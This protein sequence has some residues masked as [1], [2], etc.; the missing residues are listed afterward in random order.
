MLVLVDA[1]RRQG[2]TAEAV[3]V[4]SEIADPADP[5]LQAE[6][7]VLDSR[8]L[9]DAGDYHKCIEEFGRFAFGSTSS[10]SEIWL[11]TNL[12][13]CMTRLGKLE[14]ARAVFRHVVLE[15]E[16]NGWKEGVARTEMCLGLLANRDRNWPEALQHLNAS[17]ELY[18]HLGLMK[19]YMA[20]LL[21]IG[22]IHLL[23]GDFTR[24]CDELG[25]AVR[26]ASAMHDL[27]IEVTGRSD[28]GLALVRSN[29]LGSAREELSRALRL[30]RRQPS[31]RRLAIALEYTGEYHIA[32]KQYKH[33]G[34]L[35]QKALEIGNRIAPGGD[36]V[37]EVLRRLAEVALYEKR[38]EDAARIAGEAEQKAHANR[39]RYELATILRV[40]GQIADTTGSK[41]EAT[42]YWREALAILKELDETFEHGRVLK[43]LGMKQPG[44]GPSS[45]KPSGSDFRG[46]T[47]EELVALLR[48]N[49]M[50]GSSPAMVEV[51]RQARL[52]APTDLT[53]LVQGETGTGKELLA[54]ALHKLSDFSGRFVA[55]NCGTCPPHLLDAELFGHT[56]GAFTGARTSRRGLV[57]TAEGGT[58]FLDEIGE[59]PAE[60]QARLLRLM[61]SGEIRPL[62]SDEVMKV[63]VRIIAATHVDLAELVIEGRFRPDLFFRLSNIRLVM[64]PLRR[65]GADIRELIE[66]FVEEARRSNRPSFPGFSKPVIDELRRYSWPGNVRQLRME[67]LRLATLYEGEEPMET[68]PRQDQDRDARVIP[69][70]QAKGILADPDRLR[71][72]IRDCDG[73][74]QMVARKLGVSRTGLYRIFKRVGIDSRKIRSE[75]DEYR[76]RNW[77]I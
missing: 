53:L 67:I 59:L 3:T 22:L 51:M 8:L 71:T 9:I 72:L 60:S 34:R 29:R 18:A 52:L 48:A 61:D 55:F 21:N 42:T 43:L 41:K 70:M 28:L 13:E 64:P 54:Q 7:R 32:A 35:L 56:R 30:S 40:K 58:L 68:W 6:L 38:Y 31:P 1:L 17:K 69:P 19:N 66:H 65:R 75:I 14:E 25:Q 47:R 49:G 10:V 63:L 24:A 37:P 11:Q 23:R 27:P 36:I 45:H 73:E 76:D 39:D 2:K 50:I 20:C 15:S 62:G 46:T 16:R 57:R 4:R 26:I 12:A 74:I 77:L 44:S 5:V 33:A